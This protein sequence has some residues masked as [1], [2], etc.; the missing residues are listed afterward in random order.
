VGNAR[1]CFWFKFCAHI[2]KIGGKNEKNERIERI[3]QIAYA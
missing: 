1:K 2:E 3:E